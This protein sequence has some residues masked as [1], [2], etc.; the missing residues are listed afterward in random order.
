MEPLSVEEAAKA[1]IKTIFRMCREFRTYQ[2]DLNAVARELGF[3]YADTKKLVSLLEREG[4]VET[5][6]FGQKVTLTDAGIVLAQR[7]IH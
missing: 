6:T 3:E 5:V 4:Y 1:L 2:L 7:L